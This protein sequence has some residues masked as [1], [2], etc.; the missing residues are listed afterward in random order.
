M[1][2][3]KSWTSLI[4]SS[5]LSN[6]TERVQLHYCIKMVTAKTTRTGWN[7]KHEAVL[8]KHAAFLYVDIIIG[9][10][11]ALVDNRKLTG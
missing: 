1:P 9:H 8:R 3:W 11:M 7:A 5:R 10:D 4:R 6:L 2:N